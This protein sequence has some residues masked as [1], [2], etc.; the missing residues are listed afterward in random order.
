MVRLKE[1]LALVHKNEV[2]LFQFQSGAVKRRTKIT[3]VFLSV[4]FQFQSGAVKR[5][6]WDNLMSYLARFQFQSGAVKRKN[7][8]KILLYSLLVSIPKWCG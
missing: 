3:T 2:V 5:S 8:K 1:I 4:E 6:K 7:Q